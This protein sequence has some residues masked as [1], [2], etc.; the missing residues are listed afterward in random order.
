MQLTCWGFLIFMSCSGIE[1]QANA[2]T[3]C[4]VAEP[5]IWTAKDTRLTKKQADAHNRL[6]KRL[7][8]WGRK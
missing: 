3:F 1:G 6:G 5:I 8:G 2:A 4:D 7:C